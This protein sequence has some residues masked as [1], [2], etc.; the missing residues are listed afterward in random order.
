MEDELHDENDGD[1][2]DDD[3]D[4]NDNVDGN[5]TDDHESWLCWW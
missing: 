1:D 5:G 4:D 3:S 2:Y